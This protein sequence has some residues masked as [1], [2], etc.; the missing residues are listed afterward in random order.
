MHHIEE[1]SEKLYISVQ[2]DRLPIA[3]IALGSKTQQGLSHEKV[4][5]AVK[6]ILS[7]IL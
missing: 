3:Y 1:E 4:L 2:Q 5:T 6:E 7:C